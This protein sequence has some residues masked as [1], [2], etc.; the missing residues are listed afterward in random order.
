MTPAAAWLRWKGHD[1]LPA[2]LGP[3]RT[4]GAVHGHVPGLTGSLAH[5]LLAA[6]VIPAMSRALRWP[7]GRSCP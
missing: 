6:P 5:T 4:L 3:G 7:R 2:A 1:S